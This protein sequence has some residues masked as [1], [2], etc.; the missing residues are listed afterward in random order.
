MVDRLQSE[1][2][3]LREAAFEETGKLN[4][5]LLAARQLTDEAVTSKN[6]LEAQLVEMRQ[7][8]AAHQTEVEIKLCALHETLSCQQN[9]ISDLVD[10]NTKLEE[11]K[12]ELEEKLCLSDQQKN[13]SSREI[14]GECQL[15]VDIERIKWD[16]AMEELR[17][18]LERQKAVVSMMETDLAIKKQTE[19]AMLVLKEGISE[20]DQMLSDCKLTAETEQRRLEVE[21]STLKEQ[22]RQQE[23]SLKETQGELNESRAERSALNN[24]LLCIN[25]T[26]TMLCSFIGCL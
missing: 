8:I 2:S 16:K 9:E 26:L 21:K 19:E 15:R 24:Q 17:D 11:Q 14:Y 4:G 3:V 7:S 13:E 20:R 25:T 23:C 1:V 5:K 18:Q 12:Q 10:K 6:R 22:L